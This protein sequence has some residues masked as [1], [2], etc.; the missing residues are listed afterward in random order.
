MEQ[1]DEDFR[2]AEPYLTIGISEETREALTTR[3]AHAVAILDLQNKVSEL[4]RF[5]RSMK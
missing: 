3:N 1:C 4:E 2:K 5:C